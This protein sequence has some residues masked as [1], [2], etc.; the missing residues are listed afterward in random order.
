[1][2]IFHICALCNLYCDENFVFILKLLSRIRI[3]FQQLFEQQGWSVLLDHFYI[4]IQDVSVK[5][6]SVRSF[7]CMLVLQVCGV[8][9]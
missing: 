2:G 9:S 5:E 4:F 3:A 1:M 6:R 8:Y 7:G